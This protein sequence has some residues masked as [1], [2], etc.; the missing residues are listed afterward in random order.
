MTSTIRPIETRYAGCRF[1][2]RL[3]ARWAVFFDTLGVRWEYEPEGFELDNGDR[4]L[5]DFW[6]PDIETWFEVKAQEPVESKLGRF[7]ETCPGRL[8]IA[9]GQ[10]PD[11]RTFD[12]GGHPFGSF[13]GGAEGSFDL[14]LGFCLDGHYAWCSCPWCG[15]F[16]IEFDARGARVCGYEKHGQPY[17]DKAYSGDNPLILAAYAAARSARFEHGENG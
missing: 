13:N 8:I 6:L 5:P 4:Y 15:K 10:M 1:R 3:E 14:W 7:S 17:E 12:R 9:I 2:S 16:G 11:I